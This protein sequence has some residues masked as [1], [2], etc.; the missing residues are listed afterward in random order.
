MS[1]FWSNIRKYSNIRPDPLK[2]L[3]RRAKALC[4][5]LQVCLWLSRYIAALLLLHPPLL[6]LPLFPPLPFK[7]VIVGNPFNTATPSAPCTARMEG[8]EVLQE[9]SQIKSRNLLVHPLQAREANFVECKLLLRDI[10]SVSWRVNGGRFALYIG[11]SLFSLP[12]S[13][14]AAINAT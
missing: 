2:I 1:G 5:Q 9:M 3:Q 13:V 7:S 11:L 12:L 6:F 4:C 8:S 14:S 10:P